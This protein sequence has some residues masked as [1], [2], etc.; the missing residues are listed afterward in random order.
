M[1]DCC[2][3]E[4]VEVPGVLMGKEVVMDLAIAGDV[5]LRREKGAV[6]GGPFMQIIR[7]IHSR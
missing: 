6:E 3:V 7:D 4:G 5:L 2:V 1:F